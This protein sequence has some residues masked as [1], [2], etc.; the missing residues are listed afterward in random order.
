MTQIKVHV[1]ILLSK[2]IKDLVV[3]VAEAKGIDSS[4]Y[5]RNLINEDLNRYHLIEHRIN[6]IKRPPPP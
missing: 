1:S 2:E 4:E 5:I 6:Q 3:L